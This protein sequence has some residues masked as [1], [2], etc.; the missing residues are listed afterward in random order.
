[1]GISGRMSGDTIF[2]H[3]LNNSS[4]RNIV[5]NTANDLDIRQETQLNVTLPG[6]EATQQSF[7]TARLAFR[8][9]DDLRYA[10]GVSGD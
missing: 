10:T 9:A 4:I 7:E 1:M 8:L 3:E 5:V 2:A 6:F